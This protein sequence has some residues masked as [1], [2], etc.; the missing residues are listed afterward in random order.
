MPLLIP[1]NA[2]DY[3]IP[4]LDGA[5]RVRL[6]VEYRLCGEGEGIL[7]N[8]SRGKTLYHQC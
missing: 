2:A 5:C 3:P 8:T 1:T 4:E 7:R 6:G